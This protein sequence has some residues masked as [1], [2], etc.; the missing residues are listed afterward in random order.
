ME[1]KI[2]PMPVAENSETLNFSFCHIV[3]GKRGSHIPHLGMLV[4]V[5][6]S[7][8]NRYVS[9]HRT[10]KGTQS[11]LQLVFEQRSNVLLPL[12]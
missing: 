10:V 9:C 6:V 12:C 1:S 4:L 8:R 5:L 3:E 7:V 2:H 11:T